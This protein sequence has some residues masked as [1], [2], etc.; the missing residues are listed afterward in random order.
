MAPLQLH[1]LGGG[2]LFSSGYIYFILLDLQVALGFLYN[3]YKLYLDSEIII[4][5]IP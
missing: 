1:T 5:Y 3:Q 4:S 2:L